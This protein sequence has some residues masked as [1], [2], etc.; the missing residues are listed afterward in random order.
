M[1]MYGGLPVVATAR[2]EAL[3]GAFYVNCCVKGLDSAGILSLLRRNGRDAYVGPDADGWTALVAEDLETQSDKI[4]ESY[5]ETFAPDANC[6]A[7]VSLCH[8]EDLFKVFLYRNR[9]KIAEFNSNPAYFHDYG[10]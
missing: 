5:G 1:A 4:I 6:L 7:V 9:E 10:D 8:D 3:M 2:S